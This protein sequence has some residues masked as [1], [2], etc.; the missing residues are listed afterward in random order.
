MA[1]AVV[2][3]TLIMPSLSGDT[4]QAFRR[5][6]TLTALVLVGLILL[7]WLAKKY[8][9]TGQKGVGIPVSR[10]R[11][12]SPA[13]VEDNGSHDRARRRL[14]HT[15]AHGGAYRR[16]TLRDAGHGNAVPSRGYAPGGR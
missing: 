11:R 8:L 9:E 13:E 6:D 2:I 16:G 15:Q 4:W 1:V 10:G 7:S 12:N 14:P 5:G 3:G